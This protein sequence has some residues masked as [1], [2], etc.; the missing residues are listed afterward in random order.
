MGLSRR[1][2]RRR[3]GGPGKV[4]EKQTNV[5]DDQKRG[6]AFITWFVIMI[7]PAGQV[8]VKSILTN[9]NTPTTLLKSINDINLLLGRLLTTDQGRRADVF[10]AAREGLMLSD[11][12]P[13]VVIAG[14]AG[15]D[16]EPDR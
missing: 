3:R 11:N 15:G 8:P 5:E 2:R 13:A 1:C 12:A 9:S 4:K 10:P 6:E 7:R 14:G 16:A